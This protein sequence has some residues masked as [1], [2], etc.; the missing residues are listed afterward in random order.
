MAAGELGA[1]TLERL[2]IVN[3]GQGLIALHSKVQNRFIRMTK[4][5]QVDGVVRQS[6]LGR[7][8]ETVFQEGWLTLFVVAG[9]IP[10]PLGSPART[11]RAAF[12]PASY[13]GHGP[14]HAQRLSGQTEQSRRCER[15]PNKHNGA[16][17][18]KGS[19]RRRRV[20]PGLATAL[21]TRGP[22]RLC[23]PH[24]ARVRRHSLTHSAAR[25]LTTF[26]HRLI[27]E[28][29]SMHVRRAARPPT[30]RP[31]TRSA[32]ASRSCTTRAS[33]TSDAVTKDAAARRTSRPRPTRTRWVAPRRTR[34]RR[35]A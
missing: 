6:R 26:V 30:A 8:A 4:G 11:S 17:F 12:A 5:G 32:T 24:Q 10:R 3:A 15:A 2:T 27:V 33:S 18:R 19:L 23:R 14:R 35:S 20:R 9:P 13:H 1:R 34:T 31:S 7:S 21:E 16:G 22:P 25:F 29:H 28:V